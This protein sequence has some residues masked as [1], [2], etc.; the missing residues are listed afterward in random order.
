M[1]A[2]VFAKQSVRVVLNYSNRT[3]SRKIDNRF[4]LATDTGVMH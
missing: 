3:I 1:S 4:H 2:F